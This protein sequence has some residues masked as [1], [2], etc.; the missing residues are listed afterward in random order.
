MKFVQPVAKGKVIATD[1]SCVLAGQALG[2]D[3]VLSRPYVGV[4]NMADAKDLGIA[5]P[6]NWLKLCKSSKSSQ[7]GEAAGVLQGGQGGPAGGVHGQGQP[8]EPSLQK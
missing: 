7:S 5:W 3:T 1:P 6:Y 4:E 8:G 2:R